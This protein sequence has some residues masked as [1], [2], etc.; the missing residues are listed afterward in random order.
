VFLISFSGEENLLGTPEEAAA[1][2]LFLDLPGVKN[3]AFQKQSEKNI[4]WLTHPPDPE[5]YHKAFQHVLDQILYGNSF[6][7][8]LTQP[9]PV[10]TNYSLQ[11]IFTESGAPF[12]LMLENF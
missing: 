1:S 5:V 8:N 4:H 10:E 11:E 6:L 7:L 12:K 2:G 9:T 3:H